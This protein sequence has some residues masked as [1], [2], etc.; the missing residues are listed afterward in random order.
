MMTHP[1]RLL[2]V[3]LFCFIGL[4]MGT[5]A[6]GQNFPVRASVTAVNASPYLEDYG[7]DGNLI[8]ILTLVD[9]REEYNG[10]LRINIEGDG[11]RATTGDGVFMT[12]INLRRGQPLILRG[13]QLAPYF[14]LNN[15]IVEGF[16]VDGTVNNG[17]SL[18]D[19]PITICVE[20][21]D[22]NRFSDPPVSNPA[23]ATRFVQQNYPPELVHPLTEIPAPPTELINFSWNP[24]HV[25]QPLDDEYELTVWAKVEGL[26][27]DQIINSTA[28]LRSPITTTIPRYTYTN[29]DSP[30]EVGQEYIW[31]VR[32][33]DRRNVRVFINDG[34]SD[35]G[36]FQY[37]VTPPEPTD[38]CLGIE[39]LMAE[40]TNANSTDIR[41]TVEAQ[42]TIIATQT[43]TS[44][45]IGGS[46]TR[47]RSSSSSG[48]GRV[49]VPPREL[50]PTSFR[51]RYRLAAGGPWSEDYLHPANQRTQFLDDLEVGT[52]YEV[53]LCGLCSDG[54]ESCETLMFTT[55]TLEEDCG[56]MTTPTTLPLSNAEMR[57][58][59]SDIWQAAGYRLSWRMTHDANGNPVAQT[60]QQQT[61]RTTEGGRPPRSSNNNGTRAPAPGNSGRGNSSVLAPGTT[62]TTI[63]GLVMNATYQFKFCK[64]C[65]DGTEE[66]YE[67]NAVWEGENA[68]CDPAYVPTPSIMF[69]SETPTSLGVAWTFAGGSN[70]APGYELE[71]I[72][73]PSGSSEPGDTLSLG[74]NETSRTISDLL[75]ETSYDFT[76]CLTCLNGNLRCNT[77]TGT[78]ISYVC[79]E[80]LDLESGV[81]TVPIAP[82]GVRVEWSAL[83]GTADPA[84]WTVFVLSMSGDT[85]QR[86]PENGMTNPPGTTD[87]TFNGLTADTD[88]QI[89]ICYDC[90]DE[91]QPTCTLKTITVPGCEAV[92]LALTEGQV[93]FDFV[94]ISWED[95]GTAPYTVTF[96]EQGGDPLADPQE[97][98]ETDFRLGGLSPL[99]TYDISV[100]FDCGA[101]AVCDTITLTTIDVNCALA[102]DYEYDFE[103]GINVSL[104]DPENQQLVET[105]A[106]GDSIWAGD[107]LVQ[108]GEI[109]GNTTFGGH[110]FTG[111]PYL[112]GAKLRLD[113][114]DVQVN[115]D[116][117]MVAGKMV[118]KSPLEAALEQ[119][120]QGLQDLQDILGE[121]D[122]FLGTLS[123]TLGTISSVLDQIATA[124]DVTDE[125]NAVLEQLVT[126]L[127]QVP[128][129]PDSY[130]DAV[131]DAADCL[132]QAALTGDD[133]A[134]RACRDQL[135][136]AIQAA[137]DYIDDLFDADFIVDFSPTV[138]ANVYWGLDS[139]RYDLITEGYDPRT[140]GGTPYKVP[141]AS[142]S[143]E[144]PAGV[145]FGAVRRDGGTMSPVNFIGSDTQTFPGWTTSGTNATHGGLSAD[146]DQQTKVVFA[147][148]DNPDA[149]PGNDSI[150]PVK[151][152]GQLNVVTYTPVRHTVHI[153]P[154]NTVALTQ[155]AAAVQ[156]AVNAIFRPSVAEF[157][158][159][160][161]PTLTV[162]EFDGQ[163]SDIPE[164][165][166]SNYTPEMNLLKG[167][168]KAQGYYDGD[169]YYLIVVPS[170]QQPGRV[171]FMPR[172]RHFGFLSEAGLTS[173]A[174][175]NRTVAHELAHGAF[176][177]QHV[178][179]R[180]D[181]V[182]PGTTDNLMDN[183]GG[184]TLFKYQ[185]DNVHDPES[186]FTLFD[187]EEEGES[188]TVYRDF[189]Q[190]LVNDFYGGGDIDDP[191]TVIGFVTNVGEKFTIK[192]AQLQ[193]VR[194]ATGGEAYVTSRRLVPIG[195]VTDFTIIENN[196]TIVYAVCLNGGIYQVLVNGVRIGE[197]GTC[198]G[199]LYV[200]PTT[201]AP[202]FLLIRAAYEVQG[203]PVPPAEVNAG[204]SPAP[205]SIREGVNV[206]EFTAPAPGSD[207]VYDSYLTSF[208]D[209]L[210][211][212]IPGDA[213]GEFYVLNHS[214]AF[215]PGFEL[216]EMQQLVETYAYYSDYRKASGFYFPTIAYLA[217][218]IE[219]LDIDYDGDG[220]PDC[221]TNT[222][223]REMRIMLYL[224]DG[225]N[226][227]SRWQEMDLL[228]FDLGN[229]EVS[230]LEEV[231]GELFADAVE[232]LRGIRN[233]SRANAIR[234]AL[235]A[236]FS[237]MSYQA[238]SGA[239]DDITNQ[240][241]VAKTEIA[242]AAF[243]NLTECDWNSIIFDPDEIIL[244]LRGVAAKST[245]NPIKEHAE[246]KLILNLLN[247]YPILD[248]SILEALAT[249]DDA[250]GT[251][252]W[253]A[254]LYK[255]DAS[256]IDGP[257]KDVVKKI[258]QICHS[259]W[260]SA[261]PNPYKA[262]YDALKNQIDNITCDEEL[263]E[264]D[265]LELLCEKVIAFNYEK[266]LKRVWLSSRD[267]F[268]RY[269]LVG[270]IPKLIDPSVYNYSYLQ[271]EV[272][273]HS[274][275][276][277]MS[278][279]HEPH[280][281]VTQTYAM[282]LSYPDLKP[283]EPIILDPGSTY[284]VARTYDG[285]GLTVVP[286]A[287]FYYLDLKATTETTS[288]AIFTALDLVSLVTPVGLAFKVSRAARTLYYLDKAS[289]V[290]SLSASAIDANQPDDPTTQAV[291]NYLNITSGVLG[292]STLAG[293][294]FVRSLGGME[295]AEAVENVAGAI[296][297]SKVDRNA[298]EMLSD[299]DNLL[300]ETENLSDDAFRLG[301]FDEAEE[302]DDLEGILR[303]ERAEV[304]DA[305]RQVDDDK[306]NRAIDRLRA[307]A[308][309][310]EL[311]L[312]AL[313]EVVNHLRNGRLADAITVV[314]AE[315]NSNDF[316]LLQ[317][318]MSSLQNQIDAGTISDV[319]AI[320]EYSSILR[321]FV[322]SVDFTPRITGGSWASQK[323]QIFDDLA[324]GSN[325]LALNRLI[326]NAD[327]LSDYRRALILD[328]RRS[329]NALDNG[330]AP[331]KVESNKIIEGVLGLFPSSDLSLS[332]MTVNELTHL[333]RRL[334]DGNLNET[335]QRARDISD[336]DE[337][338]LIQARLSALNDLLSGPTNYW[339]RVI[340]RNR[341]FWDFVNALPISK[342]TYGII[343]D[344]VKNQLK[345]FL[346]NVDLDGYFTTAI[347][348][349]PD[350]DYYKMFLQLKWRWDCLKRDE[351]LGI[352]NPDDIRVVKNQIIY[353]ILQTVDEGADLLDTPRLRNAIDVLRRAT[354]D[355]IPYQGL[356]V[357]VVQRLADDLEAHVGLRSF[358]EENGRNGFLAWKYADDGFPNRPWC[359]N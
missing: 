293:E 90:E 82:D 60:T 322:Q 180:F 264:A 232:A 328:G 200:P 78:T 348:H 118:I 188:V 214:M 99:T 156:A 35:F 9:A 30:L 321:G 13:S 134:V 196:E 85:L 16:G 48:G 283:F 176:H 192:T 226:D 302:I 197:E 25:P 194:F 309:G 59:W 262:E 5:A 129:L 317:S 132:K 267:G 292:V 162:S 103:C 12:P 71:L 263:I 318:R 98:T 126:A 266:I 122:N 295:T 84:N 282:P 204:E 333:T 143:T 44:S 141:W 145:P 17:G 222:V 349:I 298:D 209:E 172:K 342:Q 329:R 74:L 179:D 259:L 297:R 121:I 159:V 339:P 296:G 18:P 24:R 215:S 151:L 8:V 75:A 66:C 19:G 14:D 334:N 28:P 45:P 277:L 38:I 252:L 46:R 314:R 233:Y 268:G 203:S 248:E 136:A 80:P 86:Y 91:E 113:F 158:V 357:P 217:G 253:A 181:D 175:F 116:C 316:I 206:V 21:Y 51:L 212:N 10:L 40:G 72:T 254:I 243:R 69:G 208:Y 67:W 201:E 171:G 320:A 258:I 152:A 108:V 279:D 88:Y 97:A 319:D 174:T 138:P 250:N 79:P 165:M 54:Q 352:A 249:Q 20:F 83:A 154:V 191:S 112:A 184:E 6:Y 354:N 337:L 247:R 186:N 256:F 110:G 128:Y 190:K 70:P 326:D 37:G 278:I 231:F 142:T 49:V 106:P 280:G 146:G 338:I 150:P 219:A 343:D 168:V 299:Y 1:G 344:A 291:V 304:E 115:E 42:T 4:L 73:L 305:G 202:K 205:V 306:F 257:G 95:V 53:E 47:Q 353:S 57:L 241:Y 160:I 286:A 274:N 93:H 89:A 237:S 163:L 358:L 288:D 225:V 139:Q 236:Y 336:S 244:L 332:G 125:A 323:P 227:Y 300:D 55:L 131:E 351:L 245:L 104:Q 185:W 101:T 327:N 178:Y 275:T 166:L 308:R 218:S 123:A 359:A 276:R 287:L 117:R 255:A 193:S 64:L 102:G 130:V 94:E 33:S 3:L 239:L 127:D 347:N 36:E 107:F 234:G 63:S 173:P 34:I 15:L 261:T 183:A 140:I 119:L 345:Q 133:E 260:Q 341:I 76:V 221:G 228:P 39:T 52:A 240:N 169:D 155:D 92:D 148:H 105:L 355:N 100:C 285:E 7:R 350:D 11:Y 265:V 61:E 303:R 346:A 210:I 294:G 211:G 229:V 313:E 312:T 177:L 301:G 153:I 281:N 273:V 81:T 324:A 311:T 270:Q 31:R 187:E 124:A 289:S 325:D 310:A 269:T 224:L 189:L 96:W 220:N 68:V 41:W 137:Q 149:E 216:S 330:V 58:N 198:T 271:T 290:I 77:V 182:S 50:T 23:C 251:P 32:V 195:T 307:G 272:T 331:S 246:E 109:T 114:F 161:E 144:E 213:K 356:S 223:T 170:M 207:Y 120:Q 167:K 56:D 315:D 43:Q 2:L 335:I 157:T 230:A 27:Y 111:I 235:L 29:Y 284:R 65:A 340:E 62:E 164:S 242:I 87:Y 199:P 238:L 135:Q 22:V 26:T 147:A